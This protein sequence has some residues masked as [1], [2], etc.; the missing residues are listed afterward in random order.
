MLPLSPKVGAE[1]GVFYADNAIALLQVFPDLFLYL[2][3]PYTAWDVTD[4]MRHVPLSEVR[5]EAVRRLSPFDSRI[6]L[7]E[8]PINAPLDFIFIDGSHTFDA[9]THDI[10][11]ALANVR[12]GGLISGH[13]YSFPAV[14]AAV[15][16][17][18]GIQCVNVDLCS[19]VWSMIRR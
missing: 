17:L 18:L 1:I 14:K 19:D 11:F 4:P 6:E 3:D 2:V 12:T 13:D 5:R 10:T 7:S 8:K 16:S 15:D 9:V